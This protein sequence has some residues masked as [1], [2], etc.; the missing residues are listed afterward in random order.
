MLVTL[1]LLQSCGKDPI[2]PDFSL[3][4]PPFDT[5]NAISKTTS[6]DGLVIYKI[7]EGY[8]AFDVVSRDQ[9]RIRFTGRTADGKIFDSSFSNGFTSPRTF[10]NL[11]PVPINGQ[12]GQISPLIEGFRKGI[13]G[14]KEGEKRTVVIP[15]ALGYGES[16]SGTNGFNLKDDTLIFDIELVSII[17]LRGL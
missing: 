8:G 15:P 17:T 14:M 4:P 7:Q 3:A 13:I 1:F 2:G 16:R 9:V 6:S 12:F 11:T 10:Q 5:T